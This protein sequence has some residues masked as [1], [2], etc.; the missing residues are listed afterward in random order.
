MVDVHH[1]RAAGQVRHR[2]AV[3]RLA[4]R[5]DV[6]RAGLLD[7]LGPHLEADVGGFHRVVGHALGVADEGVPLLDEGV[8]GIGLDAHEVVPGRQMAD[9]GPGVEAGQL[10]LADGEGDDRDLLGGDALVA[11]LLVE[12]DVGVAVDGRDHRGLLA[13]GG[14]GLHIGDDGLPVGVTEG[15]VVL[16]DVG[17]G[18]ALGV[19][20]GPQDLVGRARIDVVGAE[21]HEALGPA[22]VLAHQVLDRG[23]RLLVRRGAGVE[24]VAGTLLAL[25][26]HRVEEQAVQLLEDRQDRLA[27]D[28]GPAAEDGGDLLL[29]QQL[30]RLLGEERPVGGRIDHHGLDLLAEQPAALVDVVD[31]HQ[32]G[33]LQGGLRDRHGAGQRMQ[34]PDLDDV[35]GGPNG[36]P[37][38]HGGGQNRGRDRP[39]CHG[40]HCSHSARR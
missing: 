26:L 2:L 4:H 16:H 34:D 36:R 40:F 9:Q 37:P 25:V 1:R 20:E 28:R 17:V 39:P 14:E 13:L 33:V 21:Q 15:R 35:V 6:G 27:R 8:I 29:L 10:L 18:D 31:H 38:A 5:V 7:R 30:A 24:D 22:A 32:D 3:H 19:Q 11:Q 12:G 23:D